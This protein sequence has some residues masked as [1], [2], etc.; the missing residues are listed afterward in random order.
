MT[1]KLFVPIQINL[2]SRRTDK[3]DWRTDQTQCGDGLSKRDLVIATRDLKR[4]SLLYPAVNARGFLTSWPSVL[5]L[6]TTVSWRNHIAKKTLFLFLHLNPFPSIRRKEENENNGILWGIYIF[7]T[8][9][10]RNSVKDLGPFLFRDN[11]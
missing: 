5:R 7:E 9:Y 2:N 1:I 3:I 11:I 4:Q 6:V 8:T 10:K